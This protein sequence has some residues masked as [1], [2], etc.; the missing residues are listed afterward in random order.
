[1]LKGLQAFGSFQHPQPFKPWWLT[2]LRNTCRDQLRFSRRWLR[3]L[4][5]WAR[6][7]CLATPAAAAARDSRTQVSCRMHVCRDR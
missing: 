1:V 6:L 7:H 4:N 3:A 2:I 5:V